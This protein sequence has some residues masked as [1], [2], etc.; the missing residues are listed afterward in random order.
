MRPHPGNSKLSTGSGLAAILLWSAT[1][2]LARSLSEQVGALTAGAS[3]YLL[4]GLCCL[5]ALWW[6]KS[7][8]GR[9][10]KMPRRYL[11][12]CGF[13][14]I[15]YTALIYSAVGLARDRVQLL[16][17]A[18]VNYLW[19]G[20]TVLLS[21]PLLGSRTGRGLLPGTAL[22][23]SG[24]FLVMT[25]GAHVSWTSFSGHLQSNPLAYL[26]ALVAA[27]AWAFYSNLTRR[28]SAPDS[29][30]AVELFMLATGVVLLTLRLLATEPHSWSVKVVG[31][32]MALAAITTLAYV[33]WD[34]A[35]RK[36]N[37]IFVATCSYFTPLLSTLVSCAYLAVTPS[38]KVWIG[39]LLVV[40]GSLLSWRS[41]SDQPDAAATAGP[42]G[43]T[44]A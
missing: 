12:G 29:G 44:S 35:M 17:I 24:V 20:L 7:S 5:L 21:V 39:C 2:A 43:A 30:G 9:F 23:V 10:R 13:L 19:P 11:F 34:V 28:W 33:L 37:L 32:V 14:F 25:Q 6:R 31:E 1:F 38:P 15:L 26:C 22:A 4:G 3:V 8:P 36:G 41:V 16:E 42:A 27:V 18:L 40:I